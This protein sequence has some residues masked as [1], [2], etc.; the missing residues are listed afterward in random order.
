MLLKWYV[1]AVCVWVLATSFVQ[2]FGD[3][4]KNDCRAQLGTA[5]RS[6]QE[7]QEICR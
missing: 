4:H 1:V 6:V 7:I 3:W 2:S 5:G